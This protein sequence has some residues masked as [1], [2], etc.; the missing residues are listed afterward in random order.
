MRRRAQGEARVPQL[1]LGN[2]EHVRVVI[3]VKIVGQV[4]QVMNEVLWCKI[5]GGQ[6]D[7]FRV[8]A[9]GRHQGLFL[10]LLE[11]RKDVGIAHAVPGQ[12]FL[13]ELAE[14]A[15]YAGMSILYVIDGVVVRLGLRNIEIEVEMLVVRAGHV[16]EARRVVA[17]FRP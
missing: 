5:G 12:S 16:E 10:L 13:F 6:V 9:Q 8:T 4:A 14:D 3:R 7:D 1:I 15:C 17:D 2:D 11:P